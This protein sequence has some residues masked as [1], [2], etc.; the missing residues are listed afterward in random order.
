MIRR[1]G[2]V[3]AI[4]VHPE[5]RVKRVDGVR[6]GELT[7]P[8][9][10]RVFYRV[11]GVRPARQFARGS[12]MSSH[13][14]APIIAWL[15]DR[16]RC[17]TL[18]FLGFGASDKPKRTYS[19]ALQHGALA[20][21]AQAAG[22]SEAVLVAHDYAV[23]LAQDFVGGSRQ[24]PFAL[25]GV[26]FVNGGLDPAQHRARPIQRF[27]ATAV[28]A[29][30]GPRVIGRR[31]V[32]GALGEVFVRRDALDDDSVWASVTD[33]GGPAVMPA[34]STTSASGARAARS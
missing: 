33:A 14:H 9:G 13:D 8:E 22:V 6:G 32:L 21:V 30:L 17:V 1:G 4:P 7:G 25:K 23:T 12:P 34:C 18:D 26:V 27:L 15:K 5:R 16:K 2:G 28:A 3:H 10:E 29:W 31:A 19:D 24:A 11:D 20:R